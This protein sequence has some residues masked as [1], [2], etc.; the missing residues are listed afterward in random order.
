MNAGQLRLCL[1]PVLLIQDTKQKNS[2]RSVPRMK[3]SRLPSSEKC[4]WLWCGIVN[5]T[6]ETIFPNMNHSLRLVKHL[7]YLDHCLQFSRHLFSKIINIL[8]P[9]SKVHHHCNRQHGIRSTLLYVLPWIWLLIW[10]HCCKN[11]LAFWRKNLQ[12]HDI[13]VNSQDGALCDFPCVRSGLLVY[14]S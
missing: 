13:T 14:T 8:K 12:D 1:W 4:S 7:R 11:N 5:T 9:Y 10:D 3:K 2:S 6:N